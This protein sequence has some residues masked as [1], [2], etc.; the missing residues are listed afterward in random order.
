M[1]V[2][3]RTT[4]ERSRSSSSRT[5]ARI[6]VASAAFGVCAVRRGAPRAAPVVGSP[7][8][9]TDRLTPHTTLRL[10]RREASSASIAEIPRAADDTDSA[11][12]SLDRG[13]GYQ[14]R[15][16]VLTRNTAIWPRVF[17][18]VGQ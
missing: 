9:L 2:S 14:F 6:A 3:A 16:N 13:D 18:S 17:G 1:R 11:S 5:R 4:I 15:L 8:G 10:P 7:K 12:E